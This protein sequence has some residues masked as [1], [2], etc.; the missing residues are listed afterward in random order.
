MESGYV[1]A[2]KAGSQERPKTDKV[3]L[4]QMRAWHSRAQGNGNRKGT[5]LQGR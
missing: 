3:T 1:A 2:N 4:N 5:T